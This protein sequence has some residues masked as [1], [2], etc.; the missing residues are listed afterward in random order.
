MQLQCKQGTAVFAG[1]AGLVVVGGVYGASTLARVKTKANRQKRFH[2]LSWALPKKQRCL[3]AM[4]ARH[5]GH[6]GPALTIWQRLIA[7]A[8]LVV[9]DAFP[10][11]ITYY[12]FILCTILHYISL[13]TYNVYWVR[14]RG[15]ARV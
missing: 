10:N 9:K 4:G 11:I 8:L 5:I 2:N 6:L 12:T 3:E 15:C 13:Y 14:P 7:M 1:A